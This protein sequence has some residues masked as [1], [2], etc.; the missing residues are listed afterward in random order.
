MYTNEHTHTHTHTHTHI[1]TQINTHI[2]THKRT[3]TYTHIN[4][5]TY[6]HKRTHAQTHNVHTKNRENSCIM[7]KI[8]SCCTFRLSSNS[9]SLESLS[10]D[11]GRFVSVA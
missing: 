4:E 10:S 3:H 7:R 1:N 6:T 11:G 5:H 8:F 2:Y 9:D